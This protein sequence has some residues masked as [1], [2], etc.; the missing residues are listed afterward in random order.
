MASQLQ[1][2]PDQLPQRRG[3]H[4][5]EITTEGKADSLGG[6]LRAARAARGED[7][8]AASRVTKIRVEYLEA[9]EAGAIDSLPGRTYALGFLRAYAEFLGLDV[10][11]C[12]ARFKAENVAA[13]P[14]D[15]PV[16]FEE[17][18]PQGG[19]QVSQSVLILILVV[20]IALIWGGIYLFRSANEAM[21]RRAKQQTS[22]SVAATHK[23]P[24]LGPAA[25]GATTPGPTP[26]TEPSTPNADAATAP[27]TA[28]TK[29][30]TSAQADNEDV[31]PDEDTAP[32]AP[33]AAAQT[34][35]KTSPT[36]AAPATTAPANAATDA[37]FDAIAAA[38]PHSYGVASAPGRLVLRATEKVFVRIATQGARQ[39]V[40]YQG[41]LTK[42]DVFYVPA[43]EGIVL[44]TR[45]GGA[46]DVYLDKT[47]KG[48]VGPKGV[49]LSGLPL[50]PAAFEH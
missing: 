4:L 7:L 2:I 17:T 39:E 13:A 1:Q 37:S 47:L 34:Q 45:N 24:V 49:A 12:T 44:V 41:V 50:N 36:A 15:V 27:G 18:E 38:A 29:P 22:T 20:V 30:Q 8:K 19:L 21:D 14:A 33:T 16:G 42:G 48:P 31:T 43:T 28:Q 6:I 10:A 11:D 23:P 32:E 46:L 40:I 35:S 25:P 3:L 5:K 26:A 9:L